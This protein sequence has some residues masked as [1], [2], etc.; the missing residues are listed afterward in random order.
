MARSLLAAKMLARSA[1]RRRELQALRIQLSSAGA[2]L[3]WPLFGIADLSKVSA[4]L[5]PEGT[6]RKGKHGYP[7]ERGDWLLF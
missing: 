2:H 4:L 7:G 6:K 5:L 3:D 1:P